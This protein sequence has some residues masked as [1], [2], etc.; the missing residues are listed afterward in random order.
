[1]I[2][3]GFIMSSVALLFTF[4]VGH[5][6]PASHFATFSE[7]LEKK[8][9]RTQIYAT[10]PAF[11]RLQSSS[12]ENLYYFSEDESA[13]EI[14]NKCLSSSAVITDVAH[15]FAVSM[16]EALKRR[17]IF[18]LAYYD[19]L[20]PYVPG[21]YS[22]TA[23]KVMRLASIVLFANK[24]LVEKTLY[25]TPDREIDLEK[26]KR[27]GIGFYL[28]EEAQ[29]LKEE[30]KE[31]QGAL[32]G[33]FFSEKGLQEGKI[34]V[35]IGGNNEEYF[36]SAFPSFLQ[37]FGGLSKR[38]NLSNLVVLL[39]QHPGAKKE[40]RDV[41]LFQKWLA[42]QEE[43]SNLPKFI[44]SDVSSKEAL[45]LA[46]AVFYYQTSMGPQFVLAGIPAVQIGHKVFEDV[47]VR[48]G[49]CSTVSSQNALSKALRELKKESKGFSEE[50]LKEKLGISPSWDKN[51]IE[52]L[53]SQ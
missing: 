12:I 44:I 1:M 15:P 20:E 18:G 27:K 45:V 53:K 7:M 50:G 17:G 21:G 13:E 4:V 51:L 43:S 24:N 23:A 37:F 11:E 34:L 28:L 31:M 9:Y 8:G 5:S 49:F 38:E 32:R 35:Y 42:E 16:Q 19:N 52:S 10:G 47:L 14:A 33:K 36:D 41:L 26:E 2:Q 22:E 39:Q 46:D 3:K 6:G 30:R 29:K 48:G 40:N 25:E